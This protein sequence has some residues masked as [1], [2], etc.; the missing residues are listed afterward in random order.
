MSQHPLRDTLGSGEQPRLIGSV[1]KLM[2]SFISPSLVLG[3]MYVFSF[4]PK[5]SL[6]VP[7]IARNGKPPNILVQHL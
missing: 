2:P 3:V 5:F 6:N 4:S 7:L 1:N